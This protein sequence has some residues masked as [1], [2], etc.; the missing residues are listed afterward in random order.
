MVKTLCEL[1]STFHNR[2][3]IGYDFESFFQDLAV[4]GEADVAIVSTEEGFSP[5]GVS[6]EF[7]EGDLGISYDDEIRP[8]ARWNQDENEAVTLIALAS[9]NP[10]SLLKGVI[11]APGQNC[12]SYQP[13]ASR[14]SRKPHRDY[15]YNVSYEAICYAC[16]EWTARKIAISHLSSSGQFHQDI[17]TCH[18]EAL[19]HFCDSHPLS[20]PT[21]FTFCGCCIAV[22]Q[23]DGVRRLNSECNSSHRA[24]SINSESRGGAVLLHLNWC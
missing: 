3:V 24:I 14:Y 18:A 15:Y 16:R 2:T 11:L 7:F 6:R 12:R 22:D 13:F 17:A 20:T 8:L 9:R 23:L 19:A 21:N 5:L 4:R 10:K 1:Q